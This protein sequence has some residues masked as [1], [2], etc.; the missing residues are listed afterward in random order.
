MEVIE[1]D[2]HGK[3]GKAH[4]SILIPTRQKKWEFQFFSFSFFST[5]I[6]IA[7]LILSET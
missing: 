1:E 7:K 5:Q 6:L 2:K 4:F 3:W